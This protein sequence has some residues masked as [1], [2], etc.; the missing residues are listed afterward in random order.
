MISSWLLE[1]FVLA[2]KEPP[3]IIVISWQQIAA[4]AFPISLGRRVAQERSRE[5]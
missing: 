4:C 1:I 2:F 3:S 5:C